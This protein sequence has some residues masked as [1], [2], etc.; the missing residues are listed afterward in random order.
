MRKRSKKPSAKPRRSADPPRVKK[1]RAETPSAQR[2]NCFISHSSK[3]WEFA[4]RIEKMLGDHG[5]EAYLSFDEIVPG[6]AWRAEVGA[7]L[8]RCQ[9]IL[10]ILS[11]DARKSEFV[12]EEIGYALSKSKKFAGRIIPLWYRGIRKF[13][14]EWYPLEAVQHVDFRESFDAGCEQLLRIWKIPHRPDVT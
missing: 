10:L 7:A 14:R 1:S 8:E 13:P 9:W 11:A 5:I 12:L 6:R 4:E 2:I 3:D